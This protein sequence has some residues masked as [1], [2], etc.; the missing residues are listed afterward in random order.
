MWFIPNLCIKGKGHH[1]TW[2]G[3]HGGGDN[4]S[5]PLLNT[6]RGGG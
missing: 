2:V 1:V 5:S 4:S 3:R 6:A